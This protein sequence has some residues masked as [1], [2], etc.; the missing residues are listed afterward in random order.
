MNILELE[1]NLQLVQARIDKAC[2]R[3][4]RDPKSVCLVAATKTQPISVLQ[5]LYDLGQ[6]NFGENKVQELIAK[7]EALPEDIKWH[8]I[9]H[10]QS[11]KC[12]Q[13]APFISL[14]HSIDSF[15]TAA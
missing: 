1:R 8:F 3:A 2:A 14:V 13:I 7:R 11:N 10:L 9:G 5:D 4:A 15:E 6:R 12:R